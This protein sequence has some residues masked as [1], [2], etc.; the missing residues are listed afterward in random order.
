LT[1][2]I[3][4]CRKNKK[5]NQVW[6]KKLNFLAQNINKTLHSENEAIVKNNMET[7]ELSKLILEFSK[8]FEEKKENHRKLINHIQFQKN[9]KVYVNDK[10]DVTYKEVEKAAIETAE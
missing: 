1:R 7:Q 6:I 4:I 8:A 10:I 9:F 2:I 5:H 3:S